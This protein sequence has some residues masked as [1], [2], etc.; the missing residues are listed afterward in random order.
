MAIL[1]VGE[2]TIYLY[3]GER[4]LEALERSGISVPS[5]C[6]QGYCGA[7]RLPLQQGEVFY[8]SAPL[9]FYRSGEIVSCCAQAADDIYLDDF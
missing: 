8:E 7:C 4:V 5:Q 3:R 2:R 9:A 1:K 6:R